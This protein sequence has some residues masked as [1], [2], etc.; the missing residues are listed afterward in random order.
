MA[1][2]R[3]TA[4]ASEVRP[5][6]SATAALIRELSRQKI[7]H[8]IPFLMAIDESFDLGIDP[9]PSAGG[10]YRTAL[11]PIGYGKSE[12]VFRAG[13]RDRA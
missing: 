2:P 13:A 9:H 12:S 1:R 4:K 8:T 3:R 5:L 7:E 6:C 10:R 11:G